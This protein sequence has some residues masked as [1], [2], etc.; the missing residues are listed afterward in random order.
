MLPHVRATTTFLLEGELYGY[1]HCDPN[2]IGGTGNRDYLF[3]GRNG[4]LD[5]L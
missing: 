1:R 2:L 4:L 3:T 5:D